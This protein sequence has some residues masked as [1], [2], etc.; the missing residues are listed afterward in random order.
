M[1][2]FEK[3]APPDCVC[4]G[5]SVD[6]PLQRGEVYLVGPRWNR[7]HVDTD[8]SYVSLPVPGIGVGWT[9]LP[10]GLQTTEESNG[11]GNGSAGILIGDWSV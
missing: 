8:V 1:V 6:L 3:D 9:L 7:G 10:K 4:S 2:L 5:S 11:S